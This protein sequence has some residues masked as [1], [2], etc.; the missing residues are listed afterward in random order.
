MEGSPHYNH[1]FPWS[2]APEPPSEG[3]RIS[4]TIGTASRPGSPG[5]YPLKVSLD[6][7]PA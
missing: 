5:R 7:G 3:K 2:W 1:P 4:L 6:T